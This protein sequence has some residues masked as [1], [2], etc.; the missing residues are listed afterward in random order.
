LKGGVLWL[1]ILALAIL[2]GAMREKLLV[3]FLGS[4]PG[5]FLSGTILSLCIFIV[6]YFAAAW[7]GRL[8]SRQ[9]LLLGLFWLLLTVVF[10]FSFGRFVLHKTWVEL[11]AAYSFR[12]GNIWPV[13]LVV[14]GTAPWI[15][16]R[17]RGLI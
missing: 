12:G 16:A 2:N 4:Y 9:W 7:Y 6:A 14:T 3:P 8:T 11:F 15:A 13:V 10:E 17:I 1:V 5:L